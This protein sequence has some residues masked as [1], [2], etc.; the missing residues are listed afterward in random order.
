MRF[1]EE[2][3]KRYKEVVFWHG[4]DYQ[5]NHKIDEEVKEFKESIMELFSDSDKGVDVEKECADV[6]NV[7]IG[8]AVVL[9]ADPNNILG[10]LDEK[11]LREE[12]RIDIAR[13]TGVYVKA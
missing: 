3:I 5:V 9:G 13:K 12:R 1:T 10:R 2:D 11:M 8:I 4:L 6:I 7:V